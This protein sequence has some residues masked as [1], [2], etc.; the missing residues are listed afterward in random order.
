MHRETSRQLYAEAQRHIAGGVST[1]MRADAKPFPLYFERGVGSRITDV[2]GNEYLDYALA[3]GPLVLG[4]SH[5]AVVSAVVE[6]VRRGQTYGAQHRLEPAVARLLLRYLSWADQVVYSNT[7]T[8]AVQVALRLARAA[9]GRSRFV[10]FEGHYHGWMDN[11][12]VSYRGTD[13]QIGPR[14]RPVGVPN[15]GGHSRHA[16]GEALVL[17]WNDSD[18]VE[19]AFAER[20]SDIAAVLTEPVMFNSGGIEPI[21]GFLERLRELCDAYGV[22]LIFDEVV[23]GF[24]LALG[25][26]AERFGVAPDLAVYGKAIA[27]GFPLSAVAGR[28]RYMDL[29]ASRQVVH[30]GTFNGNPVV[31]AAAHA[32]LTEL[33]RDD[34]RALREAWAR[35]ERL[36]SGVAAAL[37]ATGID[38]VAHGVGPAF[39]VTLGV[40][41]ALREYRDLLNA[42]GATYGRFAEAIL[43]EGVLILNRGLWYVSTVHSD[44]DIERTITAAQRAARASASS[45]S[46][47]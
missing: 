37:A 27:A 35:T 2:D 6:Q 25:G 3:F 17:R 33:G 46:A 45:L 40:T 26:A 9:T 4:H 41:G 8:E 18:A 12:L 42:D 30:A 39:V 14:E 34:G 22:V 28:G 32:A 7:G 20:G 36:R 5:P 10:K 19:R 11:V 21:P 23:T 29:I 16:A 24:R 43:D 13:E 38:A 47:V 1:I 44:E 15:T 31:L